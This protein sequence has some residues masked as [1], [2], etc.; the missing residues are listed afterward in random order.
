MKRILISIPD[1]L[2]TSLKE[3][4]ARKRTSV[5]KLVFS[6]IEDTYEDDIDTLVGERRLAEHLADPSA[7]VSWNDLK[8][9]LR[10]RIAA[11]KPPK[12]GTRSTTARA[13]TANLKTRT[14]S[15]IRR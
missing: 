5:S 14:K 1:D 4:A 7:S 3:L 15:G 8:Q 6:A 13:P 2:H 12:N 10:A 11:R 9:E